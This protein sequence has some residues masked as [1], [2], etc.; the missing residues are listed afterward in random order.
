MMLLPGSDA[1]A[2]FSLL[3]KTFKDKGQMRIYLCTLI[4]AESIT[5]QPDYQRSIRYGVFYRIER[6]GNRK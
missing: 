4:S 1:I 5:E 3:S 6:S 2:P